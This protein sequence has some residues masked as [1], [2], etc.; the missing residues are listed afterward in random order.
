MEERANLQG[1]VSMFAR[2]KPNAAGEKADGCLQHDPAKGQLTV[3]TRAASA[4][5]KARFKT[6]QVDRIFP[7]TATKD[8]VPIALIR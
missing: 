2:I 8:D 4:S 7:P 5:S 3:R 6:F 1:Q